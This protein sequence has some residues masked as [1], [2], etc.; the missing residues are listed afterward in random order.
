[1]FLNHIKFVNAIEF[2]W[3]VNIRFFPVI[4]Y[5]GY[6]TNLYLLFLLFVSIKV[7]LYRTFFN[8]ERI[9]D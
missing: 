4:I 7:R 3:F 9:R 6:R 1:M 5:S 8:Y 2:V